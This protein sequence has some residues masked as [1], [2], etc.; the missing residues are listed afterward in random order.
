MKPPELASSTGS[1]TFMTTRCPWNQLKHCLN[2][3][4]VGYLVFQNSEVL[5]SP[6]PV[7]LKLQLEVLK[8]LATLTPQLCT[9]GT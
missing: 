4:R 5:G 2:S 7:R 9:C 6:N 3:S 8:D 1:V